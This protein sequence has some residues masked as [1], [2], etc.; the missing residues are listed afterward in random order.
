MMRAAKTQAAAIWAGR[1]AREQVLLA[2][3][4]AVCVALA[5]W[6]AVI[7]PVMGWRAAASARH[8]E[9]VAQYEAVAQG[10]LRYRTLAVDAPAA[11]VQ[12][13]TIRSVVAGAAA[14]SGVVLSRVLPDESG[15]LNVW[16]DAADP[17][18]VM[19]W[20]GELAVRDRIAVR[21]AALERLPNG[22]VRTQVLLARE[23]AA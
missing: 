11:G 15:R 12:D 2:A 3:G 5:S 18:L 1:T 10:L 13:E 4:T 21:R 7:D 22:Q 8:A 19:V 16:I 6:F 20:L 17:D 23:G 14:R 9:A